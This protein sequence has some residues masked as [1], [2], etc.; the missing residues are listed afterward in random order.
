MRPLR[1]VTVE[2][3]GLAEHCLGMVLVGRRFVKER[4]TL[5]QETH[6]NVDR[7]FF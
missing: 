1:T 6:H 5:A 7:I 2:E 3:A 4:V